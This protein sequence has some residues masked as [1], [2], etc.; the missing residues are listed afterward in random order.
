[1]E[2]SEKVRE[3]RLRRMAERQG[4]ALHK[5]KRRDP[6]ALGY[7]CWMIVDP[8]NSNGVVADSAGPTG[9]PSMDLD[10]VEAY[11]TRGGEG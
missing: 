8:F 11:L 1:M 5:S 6:N 2:S 3:V 9:E 10:E 4:L 7:G